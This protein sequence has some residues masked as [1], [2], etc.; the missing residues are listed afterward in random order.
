MQKFEKLA[1]KLISD[2]QGFHFSSGGTTGDDYKK[3]QTKS[4]NVLKAAAAAIDAEL[5]SFS[6]SHYEYSAFVERDG[7][8]AY[9]SISDVRHF[10][11]QW[12]NRVL[13]RSAQHE[14][15]YSG[16]SNSYTEFNDLATALERVL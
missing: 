1:N 14:K 5:I 10:Q 4:R 11:D 6:K 3:F 16:G 8:F 9:V 12:I 2:Y 7:K 13:V 15:D